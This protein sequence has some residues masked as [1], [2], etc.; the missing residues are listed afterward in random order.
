MCAHDDDSETT[1][2]QILLKAQ[3]LIHRHE[4]IVFEFGR[5][6][7]RSIIQIGPAACTRRLDAVAGQERGERAG[8]VAVEEYP[9]CGSALCGRCQQ[10]L[11]GE[12]QDRDGVLTRDA[13][14]LLDEMV[15]RVPRLEVVDQALHRYARPRKHRG[16]PETIGRRRDQRAGQIRHVRGDREILQLTR[17]I[18]ARLTP[19]LPAECP[20]GIYACSPRLEALRLAHADV[21]WPAPRYSAQHLAT[22]FSRAGYR[23]HPYL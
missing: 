20:H 10:R 9:H 21:R 17:P 7:Q 13:R 19:A 2:A 22:G 16:A 15:E 11:L 23:L 5:V 8:Q 6:Q 14:K 12:F 3:T 4:R 18:A 1:P